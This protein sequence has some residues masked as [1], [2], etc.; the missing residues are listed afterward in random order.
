MTE[1]IQPKELLLKLEEFIQTDRLIQSFLKEDN[2]RTLYERARLHPNG[3][4]V[5]ALDKAFQ[6]FYFRIRFTSYISKSLHFHSL[7][8]DKKRSKMEQTI[9]L[10]LDK[11][12]SSEEV[13]TFKDFLVDE[14]PDPFSIYLKNT[15]PLEEQITSKALFKA[16]QQLTNKEREVLDLAF[17]QNYLDTEIAKLLNKSQ[18]TV[19]KTKKRA[20]EKLKGT[21]PGGVQYD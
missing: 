8:D 13:D 21:F 19:S 20:L 14:G 11:P 4:N 10:T 7:N 6:A 18:Q 16:F 3:Q 12:I 17:R 15:G 5:R 2:H 9:L 1:T